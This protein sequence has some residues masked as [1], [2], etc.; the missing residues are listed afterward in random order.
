MFHVFHVLHVIS[1]AFIHLFEFSNL[2]ICLITFSTTLKIST[3]FKSPNVVSISICAFFWA[4]IT[5]SKPFKLAMHMC[6]HMQ[7]MTKSSI[8]HNEIFIILNII[9]NLPFTIPKS[10]CIDILVLN[11]IK[12]QCV[13]YLDSPSFCLWR[14]NMVTLD[15]QHF[16]STYKVRFLHMLFGK[17]PNHGYFL[18]THN[19][20]P[21]NYILHLQFLVSMWS[22][23]LFTN[24]M[25]LGLF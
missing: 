24:N 11:Y 5:H 14:E 22:K 2:F 19:H 13:L 3:P 1:I 8:W 20:N 17:K 21:K 10:L 25:I 15:K 6:K 23:I 12:F 16:L 4:Y 7:T 18:P 9:L